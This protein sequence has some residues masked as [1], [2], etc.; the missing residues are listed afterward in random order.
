MGST[1]KIGPDFES[2][3]D[4]VIGAMLYPQDE[5]LRSA[6]T[7]RNGWSRRIASDQGATASA[8]EMQALLDL[9]SRRELSDAA[10]K[11]VKT[12]TVAGDLLALIYEQ[13]RIGA[14]EPSMRD[15]LERYSKWSL[16]K[17]YGDDERLKYSDM[18]LR[19]FF[20]ASSP[21]AHLWAAHRLLLR[22]TD[23]GE[24]YRTAFDPEG[25]PFLLG[26]ARAVQDFAETFVPKRTKPA[27][28]I[29]CGADLHRVPDHI[30][31]IELEL[32]PL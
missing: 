11:G 31:V 18:Q 13:W 3:K 15:A 22:I 8:G 26:V 5:R 12:G 24:S 32:G 7:L 23:D 6:Y 2:A 30:G 10:D 14:P 29:V 16:G 4:E 25:L 17:K 20:A 27:K 1:L 9:P 28:A 21:S 19:R